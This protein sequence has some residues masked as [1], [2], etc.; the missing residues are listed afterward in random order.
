MQ[1][2]SWLILMWDKMLSHM[3]MGVPYEYKRTG[4]PIRAW[5]NLRIS[6]RNILHA[7]VKFKLS[8]TVSLSTI[9]LHSRDLTW[10]IWFPMS[11]SSISFKYWPY[12]YSYEATSAINP[13]KQPKRAFKLKLPNFKIFANCKDFRLPA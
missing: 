7:R 5:A 10:N 8:C 2:T 12:I 9:V 4:R 6:G 13:F 3:H 11:Y 1:L